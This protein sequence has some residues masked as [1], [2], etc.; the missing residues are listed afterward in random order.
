MPPTISIPT[1][2]NTAPIII[3]L[4]VPGDSPPP[5]GLFG[6]AANGGGGE[7]LKLVSEG[8]STGGEEGEALE[9]MSEGVSAGN[10][11]DMGGKVFQVRV[12]MGGGV[13][14]RKV[15]MRPCDDK[16]TSRGQGKVMST[17]DGI[18][19][20]QL[21]GKFERKLTHKSEKIKHTRH[22]RLITFTGKRHRKT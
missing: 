19:K 22:H 7:A 6:P 11:D 14:E 18:K 3:P 13:K 21:V 17:N 16:S 4:N 5:L 8:V 20:T 15:T 12:W 9:L 2:P 1:A 10:G